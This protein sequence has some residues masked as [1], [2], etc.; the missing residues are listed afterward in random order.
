[1]PADQ[2]RYMACNADIY[3]L[4][5]SLIINRTPTNPN[6]VMEF[7]VDCYTAMWQNILRNGKRC[8]CRSEE[9]VSSSH[10]FLSPQC[11]YISF[12]P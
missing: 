6:A 8:W 9:W 3:D 1:V 10:I 12:L 11:M 5:S 2:Q 7:M 4:A